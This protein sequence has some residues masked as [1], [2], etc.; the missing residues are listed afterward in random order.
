MPRLTFPAQID[1]PDLQ[2]LALAAA[3]VAKLEEAVEELED[4]VDETS[5]FE[6]ADETDEAPEPWEE[7]PLAV[8]LG[9]VQ[10]A[11]EEA[12]EALEDR[13]AAWLAR[14]PEHWPIFRLAVLDAW[15]EA[16]GQWRGGVPR[17]VRTLGTNT[18]IAHYQQDAY[19][20]QRT[21]DLGP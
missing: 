11:Y 16:P 17:W 8:A 1:H 20:R 18:S 6:G 2:E 5:E 4:L 14:D 12:D 21:V 13:V 9:V 19:G 7:D 15:Q 10:Q 3:W